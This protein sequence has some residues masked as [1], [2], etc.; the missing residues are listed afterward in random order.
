MSDIFI[1]YARKDRDR[2]RRLVE[3]F[4][5]EGW[6]VWWDHTLLAGEQ[7]SDVIEEALDAASCVVVLWSAESKKS[8]WVKTEAREGF[9]RRVLAPARLDD[10]EP[11]LEFRA[12]H[13]A[14]LTGW[15]ATEVDRL[16]ISVARFL[17]KAPRVVPAAIRTVGTT[18]VHSLDGLTYV[19][20]PP[21]KF[22]MGC[23]PGDTECSENEKPA[24]EVTISKG[25]WIGQTP[26]TQAA[27]ERVMGNNPSK[28][29]GA[30]LP[31]DSVSWGDALVYADKVGLRLP[32]E[33]QWEYAARAGTTGARYGAI[34]D[35]AWYSGNSDGKTHPVKGKAANAW[36]LYDTLGNVS[37][38][39]G[40]WYEET[41][42]K[43]SPLADPGGPPS[44]AR[45]GLR[46]GSWFSNPRS[47]RV[48]YRGRF[49]PADRDSGIGFRCAGELP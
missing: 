44:G 27:F 45:R 35:V 13:T 22:V 3:V 17:G 42:Y 47:V 32:T 46:G 48:S 7:W 6:S 10:E 25:F 31:V 11:P 24:H 28:F 41:Y 23:S 33:A 9:K 36:G 21:G 26:V 38:W 43:N 19:W 34:D 39:V 29:H 2:A 18:R 12:L 15:A 1:S 20:I 5:A 8:H 49:E 30:D 37:E 40:D 16:R 14:D 4:E